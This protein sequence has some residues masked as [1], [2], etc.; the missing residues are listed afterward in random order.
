MN[1]PLRFDLIKM[2]GAARL[3]RGNV[4]EAGRCAPYFDKRDLFGLIGLKDAPPAPP[5]RLA[6]LVAAVP[7]IGS[8]PSSGFSI[9]LAGTLGILLGDPADTTISTATGSLWVTTKKQLIVQLNGTVMIP[10]NAWELLSDFRYL[11]YNQDT[12]GLGTGKPPMAG[13]P[14]PSSAP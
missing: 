13:K 8:S 3:G 10:G 5:K 7:V 12:Y 11:I 14:L 2:D 4:C 9:G 1:A 6:P